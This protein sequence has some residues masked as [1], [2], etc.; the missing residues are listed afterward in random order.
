MKERRGNKHLAAILA[1][2]LTACAVAA[3]IRTFHRKPIHGTWLGYTY[4]QMD[5]VFQKDT[6]LG[7][8][9]IRL[10]SDGSYAENSNSTSGKWILNGGRIT[11]TPTHFYDLTPTELRRKYVNSDGKVSAPIQMLIE[12]RMKPMSVLHDAARDQLIYEEPT[13]R[14]I[15]ERG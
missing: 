1:V 14:Y 13:L 11:L 6:E 4:Y 7:Q 12:K 10:N 5:G 8:Y 15:Y 2:G 3:G 9:M